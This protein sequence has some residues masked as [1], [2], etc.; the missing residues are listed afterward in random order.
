MSSGFSRHNG[1]RAAI[2]AFA[3]LTNG[4]P[5]LAQ[6]AR[7]A[8]PATTLDTALPLLARQTGADIISTEPALRATRTRA[9]S[10]TLSPAAA[11]A[12]LL[13]DTGYRAVPVDARSFRV[14]RLAV[15]ARAA[16]PPA[17]PRPFSPM[18]A[19]PGGDVVVTASKQRVPLLRYP[20][21]LAIL[22]ADQWPAVT[23]SPDLTQIAHATPVLQTTELGPG[24]NKI[25]IRGIADSSFN[26]SAQS[27][28]T[29]Y[30]G[31]VQLGYSGADPS[32]KLYD[33]Q[34]VEVME[35]PQGT[36]YGSGSIGGIVRLTPNPVD[37]T[38]IHGA[39]SAGVSA[40]T[41]GEP[42]YDASAVLNLP[43]VDDR[44]GLRVVG[45]HDSDGGFIDDPHR[46]LRNIDGVDTSGGRAALRAEPGDG[47]RVDLGGV[48]QRISADDAQ[49]ADGADGGLMRRSTFAQPFA[50]T[51][52]LG[53]VV[54][55]K[56]WSSGL[57]LLS[58]TSVAGYH[59][60][61]AFDAT[62]PPIF[63]RLQPTIYTTDEAKLLIATEARLSRSLPSGNSWVVGFTL[64]RDRDAQSRA[65]GPVNNPPDII[66]VTNV[67]RSASVFAEATAA[68][69]R[70]LALTVGARFTLARTDGEPSF[71]PRIPDFVEGRSTR[72]I[73]PTAALSWKLAPG[74]AL[75]GRAQSGYRTG[76]LA[77]ARGVGRVADFQSDSI[78]VAEAGLRKIR[79]GP[80]GLALSAAYSIARWQDIQA[81]LVNRRG[82]PY[83]ANIG[84]ARIQAIEATADWIPFAGL[85]A[86]AAVLYTYNRVTGP[87]ADLATPA[88]R[89]L[90]ETPPFAAKADLAYRWRIG[91]VSMLN[92]G[93]SAVYI[94]RSV[95]G[96][97]DLLDISQGRYA[98]LGARAGWAH[99]RVAL[100]LIAD[101]LTDRRANR[102]AL[103]NPFAL[104]ARD[105]S[106]PL[107]PFNARLGGSFA[108]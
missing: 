21:S 77:V 69:T 71:R 76:G 49:Y 80:T 34:D 83:T 42:G 17:P 38:G 62:P 23:G 63:G 39:V 107:R 12:R 64:L 32:L 14:V 67:T 8:L 85:S 75:F 28:A 54:V 58:A 86:T 4:A 79:T 60:V 2:I 73:D 103:G 100:T 46:G 30:L 22:T 31:D 3:A 88:H 44:L 92:I 36:L 96:T 27:T 41:Q 93:G 81:D 40:T 78:R 98:V 84:N 13:K 37:L 29:I 52:V 10:G 48:Y 89:R 105:Q 19:M 7:I 104:A 50:N 70:N 11:L 43:I 101:N 74:L 59:A 82:L 45:Y 72:R 5:A 94:G 55:T 51:V 6:N 66:G 53:S 1:L 25:F 97:G 61:D 87:L 33:M 68:A 47:W 18:A 57:Q 106:T 99:K 90:P 9:L 26:G 20:G 24:R 91:A 102:F 15:P 56:D 95:L 65:L 16:P 35:G 108:W